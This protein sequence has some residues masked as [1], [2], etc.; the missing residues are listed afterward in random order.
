MNFRASASI[1]TLRSSWTVARI[2][3]KVA[4]STCCCP[5]RSTSVLVRS[6]KAWWRNCGINHLGKMYGSNKSSAA[7]TSGV[8]TFLFLH[9]K[10]ADSRIAMASRTVMASFPKTRSAPSFI[11]WACAV[12]LSKRDWKSGPPCSQ[13]LLIADF[14]LSARTINFDGRR[15]SWVRKLTT[16]PWPQ[17]A[18][19]SEKAGREQGGRASAWP[20]AWNKPK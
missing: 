4:R 14:I 3:G 18:E 19:N 16:R 11:S 6:V 20:C 9:S 15:S 12:D 13:A 7:D 10:T 1:R 17:R 2:P 5:S 8:L